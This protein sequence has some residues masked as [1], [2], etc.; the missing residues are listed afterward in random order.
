MNSGKNSKRVLSAAIAGLKNKYKTSSILVGAEAAKY[1]EL[2]GISTGSLIIDDLTGIQGL[3][4]GRITE[5]FGH[6]SSG[7]TTI[8]TT[9]CVCAQAIEPDAYVAI[10]DLEQAFNKSYAKTLGL[11]FDRVIFTQPEQGEEAI[12]TVIDLANSGVCSVI[13][14]DSV[15]AMQ[16]K[17]M[18]DKGVDEHTM[19]EVA[20]LMSKS[21]K[22][23]IDAAA[24][25]DTVIIFINQI[26]DK[27]SVYGGGQTTP[28][29]RALKFSASL[30]LDVKRIDIIKDG[31]TPIGQVL[32]VTATKNKV[33]N[34]YGVRETPLYFHKGFD[35][36][37]EVVSLAI[38]HNV[39]MKK[40]S[41]FTPLLAGGVFAEKTVQG[42]GN[43]AKFYSEH[44]DDFEFLKEVIFNN[45]KPVSGE[46]ENEP[47]SSTD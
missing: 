6:E 22:K 15:A 36:F 5:I 42:A 27:V 11:D 9:C 19:G 2:T 46:E 28:G 1:E 13:V 47:S 25:S 43:V 40:A 16:T 3:P 44:P 4:R 23:I 20:R 41:W 34:P 31:E 37:S 7:K 38:K 39:I 10:I 24:A 45:I 12:D 32:R 18:L 21:M 29:G 33:G 35:V 26:R 8:A 14:V 17:A 30:R